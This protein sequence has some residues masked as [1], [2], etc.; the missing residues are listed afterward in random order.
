MIYNDDSEYRVP[1]MASERVCSGAGMLC[2]ALLSLKTICAEQSRP[3][4]SE[5]IH[6]YTPSGA[7]YTKREAE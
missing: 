2:K 6:F 7:Y 4:I 5:R 1:I 3:D